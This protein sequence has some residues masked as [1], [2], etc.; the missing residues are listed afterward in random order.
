MSQYALEN[1]STGFCLGNLR[2]GLGLGFSIET[3]EG[4]R[5]H[6]IAFLLPFCLG[7][8]NADKL[9]NYFLFYNSKKLKDQMLSIQ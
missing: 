1:T 9:R 4:D 7:G 6:G 2:F 8:R 3:F 5:F